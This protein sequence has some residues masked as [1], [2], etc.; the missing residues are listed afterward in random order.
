MAR[1]IQMYA[2][3]AVLTGAQGLLRRMA[4]RRPRARPNAMA[5]TVRVI[6]TLTPS[7]KAGEVSASKKT[8]GLKSTLRPHNSG[9]SWP[10]NAT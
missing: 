3:A 10:L 5:T 2:Q 4:M 9:Q 1:K 6:V 7:M 8:D